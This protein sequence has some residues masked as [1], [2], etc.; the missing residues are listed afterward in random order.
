[1]DRRK[2]LYVRAMTSA[3]SMLPLHGSPAIVESNDATGP[4]QQGDQ[5]LSLEKLQAFEALAYGMSLFT[6]YF[7]FLFIII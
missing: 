6:L 5:R 3:V 1:M 7:Y 4:S 2:F